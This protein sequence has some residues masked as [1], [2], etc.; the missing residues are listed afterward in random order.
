MRR[1]GICSVVI[2][3]DKDLAQL[4]RNG[5]HYWDYGH[6]ERC[7]YADIARRF[8]VVPERF[9]DYLAL[10]GDSVDNIQGVPGVGPKT[11][12]ALMQEFASLEELYADLER[13]AHLKLRG[14][15]GLPERLRVHREAAFL[16][17]RLT[18]ITCDMPLEVDVGALKRREPDRSALTSFYDHHGFGP[19]LRRQSERLAQIPFA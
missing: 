18:M 4:I 16:A 19:L 7:S 10:T 3:R 8:G 6:Q 1:A 5:D 11:A 12:A 9:A 17:R 14:A 13:V 2:T 15:P